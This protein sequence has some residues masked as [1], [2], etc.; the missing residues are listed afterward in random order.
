[1][2]VQLDDKGRAISAISTLDGQPVL[3]GGTEKMSKSKNNGVD[4]QIMVDKFG[5]D[6]VRLFSM[7][8]A[9]PEQSL[10]WNE[11]GVEGMARFLRRVWVQVQKHIADGPVDKIDLP[12]LSVVQKNMRRQLH[13]TIQK[14]GDDY[15]RRYTFNTA[16]AAVMEFMNALSKFDDSSANGR[17]LKQEAYEAVTLLLNPITPHTSH[18][19]W[20]ALGHAETTLEDK[21]FP[22]VDT[23]ALTRD[24][25]KLAVQ[26]NGKL[27]ATIEVAV[28]TSKE[29]IERLAKAEPNVEKHIEA[30]TVKKIIIVPGKIVNIVVG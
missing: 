16:I 10:D 3:I 26:V 17:A 1:M 4:P 13:E 9:P 14:V 18:A 22:K 12:Q 24:S 11:Q 29:E 28:T 8:A 23:E 30:T 19:L 20:Q 15:G 6:T 5:A 21:P 25:V 2:E 7:F 27:R